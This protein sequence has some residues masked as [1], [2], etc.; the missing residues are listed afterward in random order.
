VVVFRR[1]SDQFAEVKKVDIQRMFSKG[2]LQEDLHLRPGD[3]VLVSKSKM[4]K[5]AK[6][7]PI[8]SM[9]MYMNPVRN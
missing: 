2:D 9:S 5:I 4:S 3:M 6:F 1:V 8:P 7:I